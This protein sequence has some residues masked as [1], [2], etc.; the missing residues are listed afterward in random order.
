MLVTECW[1]CC[2]DHWKR[3]SVLKVTSLSDC[4]CMLKQYFPTR[5][6][7]Q[8][9]CQS[10]PVTKHP[11]PQPLT[12]HC[13]ASLPQPSAPHTVLHA[14]RGRVT[15]TATEPSRCLTL[16]ASSTTT[17]LPLEIEE[18]HHHHGTDSPHLTLSNPTHVKPHTTRR[19]SDAAAPDRHPAC[20]AAPPARV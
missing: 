15:Q 20:C 19:R 18:T 5:T 13:Q 3:A 1:W 8:V 11:L 17:P 7:W 12:A 4:P 9:C 14:V 6:A 16:D 10:L 2:Q